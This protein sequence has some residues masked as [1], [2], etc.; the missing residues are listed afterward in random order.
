MRDQWNR[1]KEEGKYYSQEWMVFGKNLGLKTADLLD[2]QA[3]NPSGCVVL[4]GIAIGT[5]YFDAFLAG[6]NFSLEQIIEDN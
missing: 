2:F 3:R 5:E 4:P 6:N 1:S